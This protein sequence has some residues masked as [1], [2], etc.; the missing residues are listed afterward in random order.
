MPPCRGAET[1]PQ[2]HPE[3]VWALWDAWS[4]SPDVSHTGG[5]NDDSHQN[6][7]YDTALRASPELHP[8]LGEDYSPP[9][10][11]IEG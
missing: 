1:R 2:D 8:T 11:G 6:L 5:E 4:Q 9:F 3:E 7:H 10:G